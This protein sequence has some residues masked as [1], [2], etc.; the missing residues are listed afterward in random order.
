MV[1]GDDFISTGPDESL[2]WMEQMLSKDFKIKTN[3][4]GPDKSDEKELK[5]LNRILKSLCLFLF[6]H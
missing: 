6:H 4:I 2:K 5:V 3:K 1:H